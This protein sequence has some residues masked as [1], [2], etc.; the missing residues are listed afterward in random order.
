MS[1]IINIEENSGRSSKDCI[2]LHL[3]VGFLFQ[4][5][6]L[7]ARHEIEPIVCR[8]NPVHLKPIPVSSENET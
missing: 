3:Q 2:S 8:N 7:P 4:F 1:L 5:I 6:S